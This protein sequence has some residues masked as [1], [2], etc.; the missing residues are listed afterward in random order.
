MKISIEQLELLQSIGLFSKYRDSFYPIKIEEV[1]YFVK[2]SNKLLYDNL[3][4]FHLKI[5][6]VEGLVS[7]DIKYMG[8]R[9]ELK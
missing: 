1:E 7:E 8:M 9:S 6:D 3:Y 5:E 4:S 2:K